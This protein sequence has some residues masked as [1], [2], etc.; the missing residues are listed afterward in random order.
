M[1]P[2][3]ARP[4]RNTEL[5]RPLVGLLTDYLKWTQLVPMIMAWAFLLIMV[6]ALVVTNFQQQSF[7]LLEWGVEIWE[8]A[9][10]PLEPV[11][12]A[13][14]RPDLD[15]PDPAAQEGLRFDEDTLR[16]FVL[17]VWGVLALVFW[18]L[19]LLR[20]WL[21]GP[22]EPTSLKR[23]LLRAAAA[24]GAAS[25]ICFGCWLFG[26]ER[27]NGGPAGWIALFIGAPLLVWLVSAWSLS[28]G[29]AL[30]TLGRRIAQ[31]AEA[32]SDR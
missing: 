14:A 5:W 2:S 23:K 4:A 25:I 26:S 7:A 20:A 8:W 28:I 15:N 16:P 29:H 21:F 18:I 31:P 19:G 6:V 9:F 3:S 27:F 24:A 10:G 30:D 1:T 12:E 13:P 32:A 22:R 17:K 11:D